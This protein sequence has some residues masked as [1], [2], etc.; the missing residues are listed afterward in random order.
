MYYG[1]ACPL[2]VTYTDFERLCV[3]QRESVLLDT[4]VK[5]V[6]VRG[7]TSNITCNH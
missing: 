3:S 7:S 4:W 5:G 6:E 1:V 2:S